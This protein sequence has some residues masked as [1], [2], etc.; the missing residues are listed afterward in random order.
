M[1]S[2]TLST[3]AAVGLWTYGVNIYYG[4]TLVSGTHA[5]GGTFTVATPAYTG[6]ILS[7]SGPGSVARGGTATFTVTVKNTGNVYWPH[8]TIIVKVYGPTG[9]LATS[10]TL[11]ISNTMPGVQYT[12]A[13]SW[14]VASGATTGTYTYNVYFYYGTTF[15]DSQVS[16]PANTFTVH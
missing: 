6:S 12:Y 9:S 10:L 4:T 3:S 5:T 2:Y 11:T 7:V 14:T 1:I 16:V 13:L 8:G 15:L